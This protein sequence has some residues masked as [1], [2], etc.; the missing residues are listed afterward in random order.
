VVET[1]A[2]DEYV[3]GDRGV[4]VDGR[5]AHTIKQDATILVTDGDLNLKTDSGELLVEGTA[6]VGIGSPADVTIRG[7]NV[8][9]QANGD[10]EVTVDGT[11]IKLTGKA[12]ITLGVGPNFVKIDPAGITIFGTLVKIN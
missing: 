5:S 9:V 7:R 10:I 1:G 6:G 3:K 12:E 4:K 11:R 2:S 8:Q